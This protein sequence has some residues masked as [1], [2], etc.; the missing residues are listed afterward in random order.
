MYFG[1]L[2]YLL[3]IILLWLKIIDILIYILDVFL[4]DGMYYNLCYRIKEN[5]VKIFGFICVG[6]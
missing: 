2:L 3:V 6:C 1:L 5:G 4:N